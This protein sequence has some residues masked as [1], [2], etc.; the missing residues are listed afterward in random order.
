MRSSI[1]LVMLFSVLVWLDLSGRVEHHQ[2][3]LSPVHFGKVT[4]FTLVAS[5][6][7][8]NPVVLSTTGDT[9]PHVLAGLYSLDE[10]VERDSRMNT[11]HCVVSSY[12]VMV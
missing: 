11:S 9:E 8:L 7:R 10:L 1:V 4:L 12:L 2:E 6:V 3:L 5:S